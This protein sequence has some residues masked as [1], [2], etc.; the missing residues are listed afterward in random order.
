MKVEIF[1]TEPRTFSNPFN[2][3]MILLHNVVE[4]LDLS[5]FD[6]SLILPIVLLDSGFIGVLSQSFQLS[7]TSAMFYEFCGKNR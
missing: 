3:S 5:D 2:P 4:I 1:A 7:S 6:G